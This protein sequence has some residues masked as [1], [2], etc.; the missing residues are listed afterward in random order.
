MRSLAVYDVDP[1]QLQLTIRKGKHQKDRLIPL[2]EVAAEWIDRYLRF[3]RGGLCSG[4]SSHTLFLSKSGRQII[5]GNLIWITPRRAKMAGLG[6]DIR[7]IQEHLGHASVATTQIYTR[8]FI[9]DL[10][11]VF[12]ETHPRAVIK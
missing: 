2:G 6:A 9:S 5:R 3:V 8:V 1:D 12:R 10:Q 7:C 11:K 4:F